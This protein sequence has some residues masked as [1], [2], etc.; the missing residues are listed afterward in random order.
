[1]EGVG[2]GEGDWYREAG[3]KGVLEIHL[4]ANAVAVASMH[5]GALV[6]E[7]HP[8]GKGLWRG[9]CGSWTLEGEPPPPPSAPR[10]RMCCGAGGAGGALQVPPVTRCGQPLFQQIVNYFLSCALFPP[11]LSFCCAAFCS[12]LCV[13]CFQFQTHSSTSCPVQFGWTSKERTWWWCLSSSKGGVMSQ[14]TESPYGVWFCEEALEYTLG[15]VTVIWRTQST[16][17]ACFM[18][19]HWIHLEFF[20]ANCFIWKRHIALLYFGERGRGLRP[21]QPLV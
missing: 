9:R 20:C 12:I 21:W 7:A 6:W 11:G 2:R 8:V 3:E 1:M 19:L 16:F 5:G 17:S 15:P 4:S 10:Q 14:Q 18:K 13:I